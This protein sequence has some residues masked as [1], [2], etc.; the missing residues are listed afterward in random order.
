MPNGESGCDVYDRITTFLDT[1]HRDFSNPDF[2]ENVIIVTHGMTMRVFLM[3]W[4]HWTVD[5]FHK[6][7]SI[8]NCGVYHMELQENGK[9]IL[10]TELK[11]RE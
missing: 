5:Y 4:F 6:V 7:R 11:L 2:P 10:K 8:D 9:Y 3:R 1:L